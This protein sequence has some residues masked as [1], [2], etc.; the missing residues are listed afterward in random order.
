M[1]T[2][3]AEPIPP[4]PDRAS[5]ARDCLVTFSCGHTGL[6]RKGSPFRKCDLCLVGVVQIVRAVPL[7]ERC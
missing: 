3:R 1:S 5:Y 2:T 7:V 6:M 4:S